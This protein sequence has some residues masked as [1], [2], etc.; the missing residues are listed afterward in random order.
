MDGD[1]IGRIRAALP[2]VREWIDAF[3]GHHAEQARSVGALGFERLSQSFPRDLLDRAH[4]VSVSRVPFPPVERFGLPEMALDSQLQLVGITFQDTFFLLDGHASESLHFHEL[5]H[6]VQW[7]A[8][9]RDRFLL[10]YGAG[11]A[12]FGYARSPLEQIAYSLQQRFDRGEVGD[13]IVARV[14]EH[15]RDVWARV[16]PL[17]PGV[18]GAP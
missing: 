1:L 14:G 18:H 17:F 10:A 12:M 4:V 7:D 3:V 2:A 11:L 15:A 16:A 13:D 9:G 8:L 6:V 5:V